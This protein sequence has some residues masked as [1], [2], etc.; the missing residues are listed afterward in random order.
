[1]VVLQHGADRP[2]ADTASV[3]RSSEGLQKDGVRVYVV[4][5]GSSVSRND[6]AAFASSNS[7]VLHLPSL[8]DSRMARR[9][10][11]TLCEGMLFLLLLLVWCSWCLGL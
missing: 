10:I 9:L 8:S 6:L 4:G 2:G 5:V 1:M 3:K 7:D 11:D